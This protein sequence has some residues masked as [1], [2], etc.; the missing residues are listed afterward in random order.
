MQS[1]TTSEP[2]RAR[3]S[4]FSLTRPLIVMTLGS[5]FLQIGGAFVRQALDDADAARL[6]RDPRVSAV[7]APARAF[8]PEAL[9]PEYG[10]LFCIGAPGYLVAGG[11]VHGC[12][13]VRGGYAACG[14]WSR[15]HARNRGELAVVEFSAVGNDDGVSVRAVVEAFGLAH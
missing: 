2:K 6:G 13:N 7:D 15:L 9:E 8:F 10:G 11:N 3:Q 5:R 12:H 4:R 14:H 1:R